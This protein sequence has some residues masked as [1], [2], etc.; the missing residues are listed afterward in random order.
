MS[1]RNFASRI[2]DRISDLREKICYRIYIDRFADHGENL[3]FYPHN[4][5]FIYSHL[6]VGNDVYIGPRACFM[7]SIAH[8]YIGNKVVFGPAVTIRG[9]DHRFDIPGRFIKDIGDNDKLPE[10]DADVIIEDDVWVGT[11]VTILK[12]VKIGRGSVI[13]AGS[14]VTKNVPAYSV[15]GGVVAKKLRNRFKSVEE[16]IIHD[17]LLFP[18]NRLNDETIRSLFNS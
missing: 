6:H 4:S 5:E 10:N 18:D 17:N 13:A 16:T 1:I 15:M 2:I 14:L 3:F 9:G 12:G 8:I 7:A 11:N